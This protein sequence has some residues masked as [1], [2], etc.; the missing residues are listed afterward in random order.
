MKQQIQ[1]ILVGVDYSQIVTEFVNGKG[2]RIN[3]VLVGT[4]YFF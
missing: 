3:N 4:Y 2:G 1:N